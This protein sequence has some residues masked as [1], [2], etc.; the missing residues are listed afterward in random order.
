MDLIEALQAIAANN[1][2]K[3]SYITLIGYEDGSTFK[4]Y[5]KMGSGKQYYCEFHPVAKYI[6]RNTYRQWIV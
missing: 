1:F 6:M 3:V 2:V 5:Y 4:F